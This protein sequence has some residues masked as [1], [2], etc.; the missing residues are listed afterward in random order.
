MTYVSFLIVSSLYGEHVI[1]FAMKSHQFLMSTVF[2]QS[3]FIK[4]SDLVAELGTR[5]AM[6]DIDRG[7]MLNQLIEPLIDIFFSQSIQCGGGFI[8]DDHTAIL[9]QG[10]SNRQFLAFAA[11]NSVP[12]GSMILSIT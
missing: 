8:H 10:T 3:L 6:R 11:E 9:V 7:L 12:S 5:Q 1:I 4:Q 2:G